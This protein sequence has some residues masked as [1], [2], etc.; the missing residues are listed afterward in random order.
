MNAIPEPQPLWQRLARSVA[1]EP[2]LLLSAVRASLLAAVGFGFQFSPEAIAALMLAVEAWLALL[3]RAFS[4]PTA[5]VATQVEEAKKIERAEIH[6]FLAAQRPL[7]V[8]V[9]Q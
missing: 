5:L 2:N 6:D 4:V 3:A 8:Q 7:R 1:R 9:K